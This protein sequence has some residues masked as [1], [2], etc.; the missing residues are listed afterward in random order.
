MTTAVFT[1]S[2][3]ASAFVPLS[4]PDLLIDREDDAQSVAHAVLGTHA[5]IIVLHGPTNSGKT[6]LIKNWVMPAIRAS[7]QGIGK[8]VLYGQCNPGIPSCFEGTTASLADLFGEDGFIFID[9]FER[10]TELHR[11]EQ[12]AELDRLLTELRRTECR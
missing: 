11:E 7:I 4:R 3:N 1:A 12:R 9:Q 2:P 5:P 8:N 10:V 6:Q